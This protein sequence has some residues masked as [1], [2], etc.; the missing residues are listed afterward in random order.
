MFDRYYFLKDFQKIY[1]THKL[2][3]DVGEI[4]ETMKALA[5]IARESSTFAAIE[6]L[7]TEDAKG[8]IMRITPG[9]LLVYDTKLFSE[10]SKVFDR[11]TVYCTPE[12]DAR[13]TVEFTFNNIFE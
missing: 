5:D 6:Y 10:L 9:L 7:L 12:Y 8:V 2:K 4:E 11:F 13:I 1:S 3:R